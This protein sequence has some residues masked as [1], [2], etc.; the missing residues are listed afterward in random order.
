MSFSHKWINVELLSSRVRMSRQENRCFAQVPHSLPLL[1]LLIL[2]VCSLEAECRALLSFPTMGMIPSATLGVVRK[3]NNAGG[4]S[5]NVGSPSGGIFPAPTWTDRNRLR[6]PW[7]VPPQSAST[8]PV[9][10]PATTDA[11]D[12]NRSSGATLRDAP[13]PVHVHAP[14][15]TRAPASITWYNVTM[16]N[17]TRKVWVEVRPSTGVDR[18][19]V[20][21]VADRVMFIRNAGGE[22][23][24]HEMNM[25]IPISS[26]ARRILRQNVCPLD[27][28]RSERQRQGERCV[29]RQ[30]KRFVTAEG[31]VTRHAVR[32]NTCHGHCFSCHSPHALPWS[33]E[34]REPDF[35]LTQRHH[36][37]RAKRTKP[38][39][40]QFTC[41]DKDDR[42]LQKEITIAQPVRCACMPCARS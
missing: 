19:S 21:T 41:L 13:T 31:C 9:V 14:P 16:N 28:P 11:R 7:S 42:H 36:C 33:A 24:R 23:E 17:R 12:W 35:R 2:W 18:N 1:C 8:T 39:T 40:I 26:A 30:K 27:M 38:R 34:S 25:S 20:V 3:A 22:W 32:I 6:D 5:N 37:C 4:T 10:R 29:V 15:A